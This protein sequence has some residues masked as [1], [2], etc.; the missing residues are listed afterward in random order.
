[1]SQQLGSEAQSSYRCLIG[2]RV[3]V[4]AKEKLNHE[5]LHPGASPRQTP[6]ESL[7]D[8]SRDHPETN[9]TPEHYEIRNT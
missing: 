2:D 5:P 3:H 6:R 1:M 9:Q 4:F 8:C 7:Q